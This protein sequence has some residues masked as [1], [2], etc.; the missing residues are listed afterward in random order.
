MNDV[1]GHYAIQ[2]R[3]FDHTNIATFVNN[4]RNAKGCHDR[5]ADHS[6]VV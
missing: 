2:T 3:K 4:T 6:S 1:E 5:Y